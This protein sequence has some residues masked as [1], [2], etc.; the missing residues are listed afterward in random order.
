MNFGIK[1]CP[2][3]KNVSWFKIRFT[4]FANF[5]NLN[6]NVAELKLI[7]SFM[8]YK[9]HM[10]TSNL[11][12]NS[13]SSFDVGCWVSSDFRWRL[14]FPLFIIKSWWIFI[15]FSSSFCSFFIMQPISC[16]IPISLL[17]K[18]RIHLFFGSLGICSLD[19]SQNPSVK[20]EF[21]DCFSIS[22]L[23]QNFEEFLIDAEIGL[24]TLFC[25]FLT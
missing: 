6:K 22:T 12:L 21:I 3:F 9:I 1:S 5:M 18:S 10:N 14:G 25:L 7:L 24:S 17:L 20:V 8:I 23:S 15:C 11:D 19:L 16:K 4:F 2:D 13:N